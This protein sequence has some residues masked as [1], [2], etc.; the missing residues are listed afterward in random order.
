MANHRLQNCLRHRRKLSGLAQHEVTFLLGADRTKISRYESY[1]RIPNLQTVF[2]LEIIYGMPARDLF[3]GIFDAAHAAVQ[4]RAQ[5][6]A[7]HI[8]RRA[9]HPALRKQAFLHAVLSQRTSDYSSA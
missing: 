2:A 6:L 1:G 8:A 4:T 7:E 9:K 5:K 3:P